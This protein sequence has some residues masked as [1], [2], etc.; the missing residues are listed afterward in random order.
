MCFVSSL[1]RIALVC[2]VIMSIVFCTAKAQRIDMPDGEAIVSVNTFTGSEV[3][4]LI[5]TKTTIYSSK[6]LKGV[7]SKGKQLYQTIPARK[8]VDAVFKSGDV[9]DSRNYAVLLDNGETIVFSYNGKIDD[10]FELKFYGTPVQYLGNSSFR[11]ILFADVISVQFGSSVYRNLL[12]GSAWKQDTA[13][14]GKLSIADITLDKFGVVL[15]ATNKGLWKFDSGIS[16]WMQIGAEKDTL[17]VSSVFC[18][19]NG[20]MY[21]GMATKGIWMSSDNGVTW[22]RDSTGSGS[23][24]ISRFGDDTSSAVYATTGS[25]NSQLFRKLNGANSWERIDAGLRS[26]AGMQQIRITDISGES[27]LELGTSFG[28]FTAIGKK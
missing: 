19:R 24:T 4:R 15:A 25:N 14:L 8:I 13:G 6:L 16:S 10:F 9:G 27:T 5:S 26:F 11:K 23:V 17:S 21:A 12:N 7:W 1:T 2:A 20:K 18:T 3:Y 28:C 22:L